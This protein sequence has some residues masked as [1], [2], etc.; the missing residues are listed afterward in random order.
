MAKSH[1]IERVNETIKEILSELLLT[2]IKD[3]RVGLVTITAV[4]VSGDFSV[5]KVHY[6]VMGDADERRET[7]K[8]L[9]SAK[10]FMRKVIGHELNLKSAPELRFVYDD[11]L[12]R[13]LAIER[14]L[15]ES[16]PAADEDKPEP[17]L[18]DDQTD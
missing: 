6:S 11:S 18:P 14:A 8:G 16:A 7:E 1:R 13:S 3:P 12:D 2:G 17:E 10:A 5:A 4:N 15:R 9:H